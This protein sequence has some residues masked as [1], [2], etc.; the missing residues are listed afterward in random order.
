MGDLAPEAVMSFAIST[1][2][3]GK[4]NA[5]VKN[6]MVQM[7][8]RDPVEAVRRVNAGAWVVKEFAPDLPTWKSV[9][10]GDAEWNAEA[11]SRALEK[12]GVRTG[13]WA[14]MVIARLPFEARRTAIDL[15]SITSDQLGLGDDATIAQL[16]HRARL[17]GLS[18]CPTDIV[19]HLL[20]QHHD[21]E[22]VGECVHVA[23]EPVSVPGIG[24]LF[25]IISPAVEAGYCQLRAAIGHP[26]MNQLAHKRWLFARSG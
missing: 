15:V 20:L 25:F 3:T 7:E 23:M 8:I 4:L 14:Q 10:L 18:L 24:P 16:V 1:I 11:M 19:L 22:L 9:S 26:G 13:K 12:A 6:L 2:P 5:L 21:I 17:Q